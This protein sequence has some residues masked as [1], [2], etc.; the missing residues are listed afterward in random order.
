LCFMDLG[1]CGKNH[2]FSIAERTR[3]EDQLWAGVLQ[4]SFV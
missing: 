3:P 1:R 2:G 4:P